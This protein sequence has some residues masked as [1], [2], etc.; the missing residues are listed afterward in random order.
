MGSLSRL[1]A[2]PK[3]GDA[4]GQPRKSPIRQ[5]KSEV[6][7]EGSTPEPVGIFVEPASP[8]PVGARNVEIH[9]VR[10]KPDQFTSS[11]PPSPGTGTTRGTKRTSERLEIDRTSSTDLVYT[12]STHRRLEVPPTAYPSSS[13]GGITSDLS[14]ADE[15]PAKRRV[16]TSSSASQTGLSSP[17]PSRDSS[18]AVEETCSEKM[19]SV[20]TLISTKFGRQ[21]SPEATVEIP[22]LSSIPALPASD[23]HTAISILASKPLL[24]RRSYL[25]VKRNHNPPRHLKPVEDGRY[26]CRVASPSPASPVQS[27]SPA[28]QHTS[29]R[30]NIPSPVGSRLPPPTFR[31]ASSP[32]PACKAFLHGLACLILTVSSQSELFRPPKKAKDVPSFGLDRLQRHSLKTHTSHVYSVHHRYLSLNWLPLDEPTRLRLYDISRATSSGLSGCDRPR[33]VGFDDWLFVHYD[34]RCK[35]KWTDMYHV[36]TVHS[37]DFGRSSCLTPCDRAHSSGTTAG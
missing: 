15:R 23:G 2:Q 21:K 17:P 12:S 9:S 20:P 29:H 31:L 30:R 28:R 13:R 6:F 19:P 14:K 25:P 32:S 3:G 37:R 7:I 34:S 36:H 8:S 16:T 27:K 33:H 11:A 24:K 5:S 35:P 18:P 22:S 4:V 26:E 10:E 1:P